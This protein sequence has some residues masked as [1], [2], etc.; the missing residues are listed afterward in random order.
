MFMKKNIDIAQLYKIER[1]LNYR[2]IKKEKIILLQ[3]LIQ[4]K[5][6]RL[7][8]DQQYNIKDLKN[9]SKL[10]KIYNHNKKL[11]PKL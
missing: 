5:D 9:V 3:Y 8:Y 10:I 11:Q 1:L 7:E 4:Q 2:I 6:Y